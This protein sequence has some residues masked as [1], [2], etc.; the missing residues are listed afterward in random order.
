MERS[1]KEDWKMLNP[2]VLGQS[3]TMSLQN[4]K[5]NKMRSFLTMLGIVIGVGAVIGL[6]SIVQSVSDSVMGELTGLGAGIVTVI[7]YPSPTKEGLTEQE[8]AELEKIDDVAGV[9]PTVS[10]TATT[11]VGDEVHDKTTVEGKAAI[12]FER[13]DDVVKAGRELMEM[14][15]SGETYVCIADKTYVEKCMLGKQV[16]GAKIYINGTQYTIVGIRN[17]DDSFSSAMTDSSNN[18]GKI[19]IPYKNALSMTGKGYINN[20]EVFVREGGDTAMVETVLRSKLKNMYND[21]KDYYGVMN[22]ESLMSMM[23][24]VKGMLGG[25]MAGIASIALLVGGIG[26]MNMMLVSVTER[27]KEIGL[28][29]ALGAEPMRIQLQFLIESIVLSV[30]G[31]IIGVIFGLTIAFIA[32]KAMN[33]PFMISASAVT[34]GVGFSAA[35]GIIFGWMPAKRASELNPID[36]LRSE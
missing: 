33:A 25:M 9:S 2:A 35:V 13:Y 16:L 26:I 20:A 24:K 36:A 7:T 5:S 31:G 29:K 12:Y 1:V 18:D 28:R 32:A 14:D 19:I 10:F 23:D 27:T 30:F 22:M 17:E 21:N 3:I 4:I 15:M 6:I 11:V 34:I 8:I